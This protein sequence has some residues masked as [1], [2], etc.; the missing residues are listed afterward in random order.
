M[1]RA[2]LICALLLLLSA[3]SAD[4]GGVRLHRRDASRPKPSGGAAFTDNFDAYAD[5][6]ALGGQGS[7]LGVTGTMTTEKPASDTEIFPDST[8]ALCAARYNQTFTADQYSFC[9]LSANTG[10]EER[11]V[12]VRCQSGAFTYYALTYNGTILELYSEVAGAGTS[13]TSTA[14]TYSNGNRIG[15][16]VSG[17]GTAT[18]LFAYEDVGSGW[19]LVF[20][21]QNPTSDIDGGQP[22]LSGFGSTVSARVDDWGGGDGTVL[23]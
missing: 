22:G 5:N 7:W 9:T 12:S 21:N 16:V 6:V 13:I 4:N 18:R 3:A 11:G 10:P 14:K 19:V 15:L 1:V 8:G 2:L 20:N 17:N 23:P